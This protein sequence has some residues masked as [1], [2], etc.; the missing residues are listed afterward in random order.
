MKYVPDFQLRAERETR[1][2]SRGPHT[3]WKNRGLL[4]LPFFS[5]EDTFQDALAAVPS[6]SVNVS[7]LSNA[8]VISVL[9][10]RAGMI[11]PFI[12]SKQLV[13]GNIEFLLQMDDA[14]E[15]LFINELFLL[16]AAAIMCES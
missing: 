7:P 10:S 1:I 13:S 2:T 15:L 4:T 11:S 8:A 3:L 16:T 6:I 9:G 5:H 14:V 12:K